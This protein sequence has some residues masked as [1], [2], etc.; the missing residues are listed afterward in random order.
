MQSRH[1]MLYIIS[2]VWGLRG[3]L[4]LVY[5]EET[6]AMFLVANLMFLSGLEILISSGV[7]LGV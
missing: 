5:K 1:G 6:V 2:D 4:V 3:V 7:K